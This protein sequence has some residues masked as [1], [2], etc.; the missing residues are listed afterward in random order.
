[1]FGLLKQKLSNFVDSVAKAV[2][3]RKEDEKPEIAAKKEEQKAEEKIEEPIIESKI[4]QQEEKNEKQQNE[5]ADGQKTITQEPRPIQA[6][7]IPKPVEQETTTPPASIQTEKEQEK[8]PEIPKTDFKPQ[9]QPLKAEPQKSEAQKIQAPIVQNLQI[10]PQ[11]SIIEPA[12]AQAKQEKTIEMQK[13]EEP[14]QVQT[15]PPKIQAAAKEL[16]FAAP[17]RIEEIKSVQK[18]IPKEPEISNAIEQKIEGKQ[19]Q[20]PIVQNPQRE[21]KDRELKP[22]LGLGQKITSIFSSEVTL[23]EDELKP[24]FDGLEVAL[25]ESDVSFD[26]TEHFL[27]NLKRELAN[28]KFKKT[29]IEGQLKEKI[30]Q[31]LNDILTKNEFKLIEK[32]GEKKDSK[33]P[34]VIAFIGPNGA[35]K[36]TTIA[37]I[38][39]LLKEKGI[40]SIIAA[41]DTFRAAAIEQAMH[42]GKMLEIKVVKRDY[43][44]DPA[45]VA[46]DAISH[47]KANG[48]KV[49]LIDTAGRQETSANLM[50]EM[51]KIMRIAKPDAKIFI[52]ESIAGSTLIEQI[53]KFKEELNG[54]DGIVLTKIDCDAKGGNA[55]SI[56]F[57]TNLPIIFLGIGQ[58]YKDLI[59]F[60]AQF[61][62]GNIMKE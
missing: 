6:P 29:G 23:K 61:I 52:G 49:V 25:L 12:K 54:L 59:E 37:K 1:M 31:I 9:I 34:Y 38:A 22:K 47:A 46:F 45:A 58:E 60:N 18:I 53:K 21:A 13:K 56:A 2:G 15:Q 20:K 51:K 3:A 50:N 11:A 48:I 44:S 30:G 14:K 8:K 42:H 35:G 28:K 36:T 40:T 16:Q 17:A 43:G 5:Q 26:T 62:I 57:E 27:Q 19:I 32:I 41:A 24:L 39:S 7:Q 4:E 55:L 33:E 10:K